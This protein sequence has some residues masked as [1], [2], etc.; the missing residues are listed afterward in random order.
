MSS[1]TQKHVDHIKTKAAFD[2]L[3]AHLQTD[4]QQALGERRYWKRQQ[5]LQA[6]Q[7]TGMKLLWFQGENPAA[8]IFNA[9]QVPMQVQQVA[10]V[11]VQPDEEE[12]EGESPLSTLLRAES[13]EAGQLPEALN[14]TRQVEGAD[15]LQVLLQVQEVQDLL[16]ATNEGLA[17][18]E[19]LTM[20]DFS[21]AM[22]SV[23]YHL[24]QEEG[25]ACYAALRRW[26]A[27]GG[28][29]CILALGEPGTG[30]TFLFESL[31]KVLQAEYLEFNC[32]SWTTDEPLVQ[33]VNVKRFAE[34]LR[35]SLTTEANSIE[36]MTKG[37]LTWIALRS[38]QGKVVA[39][40]DE[41]DKAP[42]E[43]EAILLRFLETGRVNLEEG[44]FVQANLQNLVIG[45][46]SNQY[47]PHQQAT[48]RRF[49]PRIKMN[50]LPE[51]VEEGLVR[52][53]LATTSID[54]TAHVQ[55]SVLLVK[56]ANEIRKAGL[57]SPAINEL[58]TL[59]RD[60][61][62]V[63][64]EGDTRIIMTSHLCKEEGEEQV[65]ERY[66]PRVWESLQRIYVEQPV[67]E[68]KA[69]AEPVTS[70]PQQT[71]NQNLQQVAKNKLYNAPKEG[72][73]ISNKKPGTCEDTGVHLSIG[74]GYA[75]YTNGKWIPL[76]ASAAA[77]RIRAG[78]QMHD[79]QGRAITA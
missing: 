69:K 10:G 34:S 66:A 43:A 11:A 58:C 71:P 65:I 36:V 42:E 39:C 48:L 12:A 25:I 54:K 4:L 16:Q 31:S 62:W 45:A 60:L 40:I 27:S 33:S 17:T 18:S 3:P 24:R 5:Y 78:Q 2:A 6:E 35:P 29:L 7:Q 49:K 22:L 47:R 20:Q 14:E 9:P 76:S 15:P 68:R 55:L 77:A 28:A 70:V 67:V 32:N 61:E 30:K 38:Q 72:L 44:T 79:T 56:T 63:A 13:T 26:Q 1:T 64:S 41:L 59:A 19:V 46:T 75:L 52:K 37:F 8:T 21:T 73:L 23:G 53:A 57:S 74:Q 50:Y 51:Q